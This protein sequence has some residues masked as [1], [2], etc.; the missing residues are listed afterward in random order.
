MSS[1][2]GWV[3]G[4]IKS[5][6]GKNARKYFAD[7]QKAVATVAE[8]H[9][10]HEKAAPLLA[11]RLQTTDDGTVRYKIL[12]ALV[13]LRRQAPNLRLDA[14]AL[15]RSAE[16]T[17]D[18]VGELRKWG[19][20]LGGGSDEPPSSMVAADPLRAAH[21]LLVDL[22][23]DKEVH[24]TQR[25]FLLLELIYEE[26]F[27]D[28]WRGL[29]SK[30]AR[31]RASSLELVENIVKPPLRARVVDLVGDAPKSAR[32]VVAD[33]ST[34]EN[35]L[36]DILARGGSTM[37]TLAEYR[38][39]E[40]GVDVGDLARGRGLESGEIARKLGKRFLERAKDL[41]EPAATGATRAPA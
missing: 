25:L 15:T 17:L 7:V 20:A 3:E 29:R 14:S 22:V 11:K 2:Y 38:A 35:A 27:E 23:R 4:A 37:R 1:P 30:N 39:V 36:R 6:D 12:R 8:K 40:L 24:A 13:K 31:R 41:L 32:P 16:L 9:A 26:D 5:K 18:H 34:Y 33:E 21:H 28:V 10:S 19:S